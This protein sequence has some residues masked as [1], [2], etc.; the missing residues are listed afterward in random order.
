MKIT[1]KV[2]IIKKAL[3]VNTANGTSLGPV[4]LVQMTMKIEEHSFRHNFNMCTKVKQHLII[5]LDF[6]QR[7]IL[8]YFWTIIIKT[9][10]TENSFCSEKRVT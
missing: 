1:Y 8:G 3:Q 10:W 5:G 6:A 4:G 7:C 9:R 2:N